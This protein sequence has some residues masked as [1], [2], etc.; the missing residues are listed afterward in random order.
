VLPKAINALISGSLREPAKAK[1]VHSKVLLA[2]PGQ[3]LKAA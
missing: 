2:S 1:Q 3:G